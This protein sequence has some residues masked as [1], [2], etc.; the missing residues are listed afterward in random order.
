M[1][2]AQIPH[3]LDV[4]LYVRVSSWGYGYI[5]T[6]V[7]IR[8]SVI[9]LNLVVRGSLEQGKLG[10]RIGFNVRVGMPRSPS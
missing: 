7:R 2:N 5:S 4:L 10:I 1:Q 8:V 3:R 9:R 6:K